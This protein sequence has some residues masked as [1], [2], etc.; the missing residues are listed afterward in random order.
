MSPLECV[1]GGVMPTHKRFRVW[2]C[3]VYVLVNRTERRKEWQEK[4]N[5][6]YFVEYSEDTKSWGV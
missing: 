5:T 3:K 4:A 2:G 1:P 6:C